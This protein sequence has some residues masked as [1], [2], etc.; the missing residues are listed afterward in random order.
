MPALRQAG[1]MGLAQ[2]TPGRR[3]RYYHPCDFSKI[4]WE[5]QPINTEPVLQLLR[6]GGRTD[7]VPDIFM[8]LY[9]LFM[10]KKRYFRKT[11][12]NHE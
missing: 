1:R 11:E 12:L 5:D 2:R 9:S 7:I 6:V 8:Q 10:Q 3:P 4:C